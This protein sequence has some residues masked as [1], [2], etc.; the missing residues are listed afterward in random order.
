MIWSKQHESMDPSWCF[1]LYSLGIFL[2][3]FWFFSS[4]WVM[5]YSRWGLFLYNLNNLKLVCDPVIRSQTIGSPFVFGKTGDRHHECAGAGSMQTKISE[6][7]FWHLNGS[8]SKRNISSSEWNN[9][10]RSCKLIGLYSLQRCNLHLNWA[11]FYLIH[12]T[13][14]LLCFEVLTFPQNYSYK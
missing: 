2:I 4:S 3:H 6:K 14:T 9:I 7:Y 12:I 13:M 8:I 10:P 1:W 5:F 11:K